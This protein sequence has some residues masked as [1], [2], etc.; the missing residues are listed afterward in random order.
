MGIA[1]EHWLWVCFVVRGGKK[2]VGEI[3]M[4]LLFLGGM[5]SK[6]IEDDI[7][8]Q[9]SGAIQNAANVLQWNIIKGLRQCRDVEL[10][11]ASALFLVSWPRRYRTWNIRKGKS[12]GVEFIAFKNFPVYKNISRYIHVYRYLCR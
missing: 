1:G 7:Y 5:F 9:S 8:K 12:G 6:E 10:T 2:M 4:K 11:I 3:T